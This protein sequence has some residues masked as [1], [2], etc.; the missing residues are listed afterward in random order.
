MNETVKDYRPLGCTSPDT[1]PGQQAQGWR[2]VILSYFPAHFA[3]LVEPFA[4]FGRYLVGGGVPS[5]WQIG[6]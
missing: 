3:R 2:A 4:G 1:L 5:A 6:S